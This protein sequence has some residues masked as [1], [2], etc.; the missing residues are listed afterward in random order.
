MLGSLSRHIFLNHKRPL[1]AFCYTLGHWQ[2]RPRVRVPI[3][4]LRGKRDAFLN[5]KLAEVSLALCNR[6][7]LHYFPNTTH[8]VQLEQAPAVNERLL[9]FLAENRPE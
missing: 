9:T 6:N 2:P 4:I 3:E 1:W 7:R 8:W 5:T